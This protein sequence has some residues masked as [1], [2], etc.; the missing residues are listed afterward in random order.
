MIAGVQAE[1]RDMGYYTGEV[2]GL[3]GPLTRQALKDY[4]TDH[5]LM[6]TEAI[7]EPTLDALEMS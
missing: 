1:L 4:Q 5:G 2:D 7:D 6:V 3:L